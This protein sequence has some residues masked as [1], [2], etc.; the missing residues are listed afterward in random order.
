MNIYTTIKYIIET[1]DPLI[2]NLDQL[3]HHLLMIKLPCDLI[4][5]I[6]IKLVTTQ[7]AGKPAQNSHQSRP[8][9]HGIFFAVSSM[10]L[11]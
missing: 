1:H 7:P 4:Y 10:A 3:L 6:S 5:C 11:L 8:I 9:N 2:F